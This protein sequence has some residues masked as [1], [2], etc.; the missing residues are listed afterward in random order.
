VVV[1]SAS[2]R[3]IEE[4]G[5]RDRRIPSSGGSVRAASPGEHG[6]TNSSNG[7]QNAARSSGAAAFGLRGQLHSL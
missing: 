2:P 4:I 6:P 5:L 1:V 7:R 3:I